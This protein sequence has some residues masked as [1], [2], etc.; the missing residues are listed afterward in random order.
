MRRMSTLLD[1]IK[2][3]KKLIII[4]IGCVLLPIIT[5][6]YLFYKDVQ[7]RITDKKIYTTKVGLQKIVENINQSILDIMDY[8]NQ[9]YTEQ[10]IYQ[11]LENS[12]TPK[13]AFIDIYQD[14]L[15]VSLFRNMPYYRQIKDMKILTDNPTILN[16]GRLE[17][18][19]D[20][21]EED[22]LFYNEGEGYTLIKKGIWID[23]GILESVSSGITRYLHIYRSLNGY[24]YLGKYK[25][26]LQIDLSYVYFYSLLV[27]EQMEEELYLVDNMGRIICTNG[28]SISAIESMP[29]TYFDDIEIDEEKLVLE[30]DIMLDGW[31]LVGI[32]DQQKIYED[33]KPATRRIYV[34]G[35]MSILVATILIYIVGQSFYKRIGVM[36]KHMHS[37]SDGNFIPI[38]EVNESKDE[39]G[40][41]I[42]STNQMTAELKALIE[43]KYEMELLQ[44]KIQLEKKQAELH[45]LQGQVNPHFMFNALEALRLRSVMKGEVE[46]ARMI[47]YMAKMF[48]K[49]ITW[50]SDWITVKEEVE[51]I[52]EFLQIQKYRFDDELEYVI[53]VQEDVLKYRIPKMI[54]QPIVENACVHGVE[55][56][57]DIRL[58]KLSINKRD[59]KLCCLVE[60]NGIGM[61]QEKIDRLLKIIKDKDT[62][63]LNI[64]MQNVFTRL[65]L[66]YGEES[67]FYIESRESEYTKIT[68]IVP[69]QN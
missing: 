31:H 2:L 40:I 57:I 13:Q 21:V 55:N 66:Y 54:L 46:T 3:R 30:K 48:R 56:V 39:I 17:N 23:V 7:A 15:K 34:M 50:G 32:L 4:Y 67:R 42:K 33:I 26:I 41:L 18:I 45:A 44:T 8:S 37:M 63:H 43:N 60:D 10:E 47:K 24:R 9:F 16:S 58:I 69:I 38:E 64:G 59:D 36:M 22:S 29:F 49:L 5:I 61:S 1:D 65:E 14:Y 62:A 19:G 27:N 28:A 68:L 51:F 6:N 53:D 20:Q 11:I 12:Y 35:F 52:E 25:K